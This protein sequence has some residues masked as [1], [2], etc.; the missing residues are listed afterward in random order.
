[1][2]LADDLLEQA[3]FL[4]QRE[5]GR[6]RQVS[7]RRAMSAAYHALF[8]LLVGDA[9]SAIVAGSDA[10]GLRQLTARAFE[11]GTMREAS[12]SFASRQLPPHVERAMGAPQPSVE[13]QLVAAVFQD[14]QE[15][16]HESDYNT[17]RRFTRIEAANCVTAARLAFSSWRKIR[18]TDGARQYLHALFAWRSWK[19]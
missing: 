4:S 14:L 9:T 16:R 5:R 2:S 8:H 10:P 3:T 12:R 7:L 1:M 13:L 17:H 18:K 15:A 19:R 6:P 11:H